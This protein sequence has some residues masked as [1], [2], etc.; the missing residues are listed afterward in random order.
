MNYAE[1]QAEL[2]T[3]T[4]MHTCAGLPGLMPN[5]VRPLLALAVEVEN[6]PSVEEMGKPLPRIGVKDMCNDDL[7]TS[8]NGRAREHGL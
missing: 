2:L 6:R 1:V 3:H 7:Y 8:P 4:H 5:T